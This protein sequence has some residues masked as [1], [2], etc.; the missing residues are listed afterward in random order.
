LTS[1]DDL[2]TQVTQLARRPQ[3][4][5]FLKEAEQRTAQPLYQR[6]VRGTLAFCVI[7]E[8]KSQ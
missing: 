2:T 1:A 7:F 6:A 4:A 8:L 3:N 5:Q